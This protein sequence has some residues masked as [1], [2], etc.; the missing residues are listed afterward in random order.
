MAQTVRS[1]TLGLKL[2]LRINTMGL[3][4]VERVA[5]AIRKSYSRR[6]VASRGA[7]CCAGYTTTIHATNGVAATLLMR[8]VATLRRIVVSDHNKK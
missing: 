1:N 4:V 7:V 3:M 8:R 6:G 5:N 2:V